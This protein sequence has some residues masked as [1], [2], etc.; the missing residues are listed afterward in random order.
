MAFSCAHCGGSLDLTPEARFGVCPFCGSSVYLDRS[1]AV[2]HLVAG[3]TLDE[4]KGKARLQS[5]MAGN[6]TVKGL[7]QTAVVEPPALVYFPLWRFV[8][9][10]QGGERQW[11]E[12]ARASTVAGLR[13]ISLSGSALRHA[14]PEDVASLPLPEPEVRLE[15]A[16][17]W[18]AGK[19]VSRSDIR[20][21]SLVH[22]PLYEF[23]YSW[24]GRSWKAA[25]DGASGRVLVSSY[26][27]KSEAPYAFVT[28][29]AL[30]CFLGLGFAIPNV[31]L[32]L[33]AF[34]VA[35]VPLGFLALA[36]VRKV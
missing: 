25:V 13:E 12:P 35:S 34:L 29:L 1:K 11:C 27:A 3:L 7:E 10:T 26:P 32:R 19:G 17:E 5:W 28:A 24:G 31:L 21:T 18:L 4:A 14:T 20:E 33:A 2:L 23:G 8:S 30:A 16:I 9:G 6:D 22:L 36:V 15:S